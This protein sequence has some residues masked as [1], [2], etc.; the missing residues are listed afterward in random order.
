MENMAF[1]FASR[2]LQVSMKHVDQGSPAV[3]ASWKPV[4]DASVKASHS[5]D[6]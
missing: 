6:Q 1:L 5:G 4:V 3:L 2:I